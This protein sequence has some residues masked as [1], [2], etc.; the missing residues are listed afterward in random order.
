MQILSEFSS[1]QTDEDDS[2]SVKRTCPIA[3]PPVEAFSYIDSMFQ[4]PSEND[5]RYLTFYD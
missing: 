5:L 1:D 4:H 2:K 3:A